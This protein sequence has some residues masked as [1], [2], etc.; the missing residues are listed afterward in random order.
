MICCRKR[1]TKIESSNEDKE[2]NTQVMIKAFWNDELVAFVSFKKKIGFTLRRRKISNRRD[3]RW[4][5]GRR[6]LAAHFLQH[7]R[8]TFGARSGCTATATSAKRQFG[9]RNR[10][11]HA[12]GYD[13]WSHGRSYDRLPDRFAALFRT[14]ADLVIQHQRR[15]RRFYDDR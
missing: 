15:R 3:H 14:A 13:G 7:D 5:A 12:A 8:A 6:L 1:L 10:N 2:R 11:R 4:R 9:G